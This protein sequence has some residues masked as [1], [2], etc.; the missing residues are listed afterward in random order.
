MTSEINRRRV[1]ALSLALALASLLAVAILAWH[2]RDNRLTALQERAD[3]LARLTA[4]DVATDLAPMIGLLGQTVHLVAQSDQASDDIL[5]PLRQQLQQ[6]PGLRAISWIDADGILRQVLHR[7]LPRQ[8]P[9]LDLSERPHI[10]PQIRNPAANSLQVAPPMPSALSE[11]RT[12][13]LSR[14]V[15]GPDGHLLGIVSLALAPEVLSSPLHGALTGLDGG[16]GVFSLDGFSF[17]LEPD[18]GQVIGHSIAATPLFKAFGRRNPASHGIR[19]P[20]VTPLTGLD[21]QLVGFAAIP[22]TPL[23]V[24]VGLGRSRVLKEWRRETAGELLAVLIAIAATLAALTL[25]GTARRSAAIA[26]EADERFRLFGDISP[27]ALV[28]TSA[29][30][31]RVIYI[32]DQAALAFGVSTGHAPGLN[33]AE[34]WA[35]P[36]DRAAM[37]ARLGREGR[38]LAMETLLRRAD[39]QEFTV[40]LSAALGHLRGE[41]VALV[42]VQDISTH[43]RLEQE[44]ARSNAELEQFSYAVSHDLQEPLRMI[45]SYLRLL[46][47]RFGDGLNAEAHEFLG[48]AAD[49]AVRMSRMINDLLDYSRVHAQQWDFTTA[50]LNT[51]LTEAL[52]NLTTQVAECEGAIHAEPLPTLAV[53]P[54][55]IMRVL[56]NLV[57]NALKYRHPDHRPDITVSA[58]RQGD[59]WI[60]SVRDNGL[61]FDG[62][63]AERLFLPFQRLHGNAI[64]GTGIGLALC[65]RIVHGHGGR[66]WAESP[67]PDQGASFHFSL[68]ATRESGTGGYA[69]RDP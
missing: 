16:A 45:A 69:A 50:D 61:G 23:I 36:E 32:N 10:R 12:W 65:R 4:R 53:E 17:A 30:D 56:Q 52:A 43:K 25:G 3:S 11:Q 63:G 58:R 39:G 62:A 5:E 35:K 29:V 49:G 14:P 54:S 22:A 34:F 67:G 21:K 38:I 26:R 42:T 68:P 59:D 13:F 60:I 33:A 8:A 46:E 41:P 55:Q 64:A 9:P 37:T 28:L 48:Y 31:N 15:L 57:G 20:A 27:I 51:L 1:V 44:L 24:H 19:Q 66:I 18:G 40:L 47:R 2:Q 7:S 6:H